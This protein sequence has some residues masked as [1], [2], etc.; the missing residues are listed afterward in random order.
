MVSLIAHASGKNILMIHGFGWVLKLLRPVTSMV[1]KAFGS[2][3]Y[4][5]S[6]S[7]YPKPYCVKSFTESVL[8]TEASQ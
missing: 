1:D 5:F 3:C 4:D 2:L 6:L 8:E 7:A